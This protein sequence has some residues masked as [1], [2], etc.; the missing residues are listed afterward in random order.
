VQ[1]RFDTGLAGAAEDASSLAACAHELR[2]D[3]IGLPGALRWVRRRLAVV[4]TL[5]PALLQGC[6]ATVTAVRQ[7]LQVPS[8]L[9]R[10]RVLLARGLS[11]L[12]CPVGLRHRHRGGG[13][14]H[15]GL[16]QHMGP[17]RVLGADMV[18]PAK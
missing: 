4:R 1:L 16:Q 11:A 6:A 10:L 5:L 2:A 17:D 15:G 14:G 8:A 7:C 3:P 18:A 12:A 9:E 13:D